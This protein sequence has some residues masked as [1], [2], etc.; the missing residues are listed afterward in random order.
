MTLDSATTL[1]LIGR[2][3]LL[4]K[5]LVAATAAS[6]PSLVG[7]RAAASGSVA[8]DGG[9]VVT[10]VASPDEAFQLTTR[11]EV[12]WYPVVT[13]RPTTANTGLALDL[14]P[15][16]TSGTADG[17]GITWLD[18]CDS[19]VLSVATGTVGTARVGVF[20]TSVEF[21]SRLF[22]GAPAKD[23]HFT[24]N[25]LPVITIGGGQSVPLGAVTQSYKSTGVTSF[26]VSNSQAK[27]DTGGNTG[28]Y[29]SVRVETD[30][31]DLSLQAFSSTYSAD[32][33]HYISAARVGTSGAGGLVV[34]ASSVGA[35]IRFLTGGW[36]MA[37]SQRMVIDSVGNVGIGVKP[38]FA[39][40]R[41]VVYLAE[42][43]VAPTSTP[44]G[45]GVLFV[46]GS[47]RL[48]YRGPSGTTTIVA[49]A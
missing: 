4:K 34:N 16:G 30:T 5:G 32:G 22:N 33:G 36:T 12:P 19:D 26:S 2:R 42:A 46:D 21:G 40:G 38:D 7:G 10:P 35:P 18:V 31:G 43:T 49:A 48:A 6:A 44:A 3:A 41:G 13:L 23:V 9:L 11:S 27:S 24:I 37:T 39:S 20:P 17:N 25:G 45:G 28:S 47:G 8:A 1:L 14:M 29:A 15:N